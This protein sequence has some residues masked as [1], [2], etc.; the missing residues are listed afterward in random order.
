MGN[1]YYAVKK[2][3]VPGVYETWDECK[4][5]ISGVSGAKFKSFETKEEA[6]KYVGSVKA[7]KVVDA[8][9]P[10]AIVM[11]SY[12]PNTR[13]YGYAAA[14]VCSNNT[15]YIKGSASEKGMSSLKKVAG[16]MLGI[17][18]VAREAIKQKLLELTI[19]HESE[20]A[21][22]WANGDWSANKASTN[23]FYNEM[24]DLSGEILLMYSPGYDGLSDDILDHLENE[25][26]MIVGL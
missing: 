18:E 9:A 16:E 19:Y 10:H 14:L 22:A 3:L 2:G 17:K 20:S 1:K 26:M 21:G 23:S 11:G 25:A 6:E 12:N 7:P 5:Q 8:N 4:R 13:T 24:Y 15:T